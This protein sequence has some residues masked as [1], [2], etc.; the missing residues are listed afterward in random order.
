MHISKTFVDCGIFPKILKRIVSVYEDSKNERTIRG[1]ENDAEDS[2]SCFFSRIAQSV[3]T[4]DARVVE[5]CPPTPASPREDF[6]Q[7]F[8]DRPFFP[9]TTDVST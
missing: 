9:P 6:V 7:Q 3:G 2:P 5:E 8:A 1:H 4:T